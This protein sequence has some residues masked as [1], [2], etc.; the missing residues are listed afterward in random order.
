MKIRVGAY[1]RASPRPANH[2]YRNF[3]YHYRILPPCRAGVS[4]LLTF[5]VDSMGPTIREALPS[6]A[7]ADPERGEPRFKVLRGPYGLGEGRGS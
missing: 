2:T 7:A 3:R 5:L 6:L 4:L 1:Y